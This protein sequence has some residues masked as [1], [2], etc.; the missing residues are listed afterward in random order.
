MG[1]GNG[2]EKMEFGGEKQASRIFCWMKMKRFTTNFKMERSK[3]KILAK[4]GRKWPKRFLKKIGWKS[5]IYPI[6]QIGSKIIVFHMAFYSLW[7]KNLMKNKEKIDLN[8]A[9]I[10]T[11]L[12]P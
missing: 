1:G 4:K 5:E 9:S 10:N 6:W 7:S 2:G 3:N 8:E 11:T 12:V